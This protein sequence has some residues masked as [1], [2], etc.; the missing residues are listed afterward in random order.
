[1][2]HVHLIRLDN[3]SGEPQSKFLSAET[4]ERA[5]ADDPP[6]SDKPP[7]STAGEAH[8]CFKLKETQDL[9]RRMIKGATRAQQQGHTY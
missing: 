1:M 9:E 5:K 7:L 2:G 8:L 4:D 3:G 6:G